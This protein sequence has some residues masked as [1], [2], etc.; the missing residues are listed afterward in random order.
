MGFAQADPIRSP[1]RAQDLIARQR[2]ADY[3]AGDLENLY[4][5]LGLE[6]FFLFAYG[7][8]T[9]SIAE[10]VYP[11]LSPEPLSAFEAKA[12]DFVTEAGATHPSALAAAF[13]RKR[14]INAWGGYSQQTK[15]ALER[16]HHLGHLRVAR[17]EKGIRVYERMPR[18]ATGQDPALR[19]ETILAASLNA[20]GPASRR[21]LLSET[22]HFR[23]LSPTPRSRNAAIERLL[24]AGRAESLLVDGVEYLCPI[25][26]SPGVEPG[27][28]R[29]RILAPFD[30]L[31]R[32]RARFEHLW[33][34]TYRFEAY[35]PPSK[36]KLGYYAM[37]VLWRGAII[38]WANAAAKN[39]RLSLEFGFVSGTKPKDK[40]FT[41]AAREEAERLAA[42]L[43]AKDLQATW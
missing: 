39:G 31:V 35:T 6:E 25:G 32:D 12:L 21:F 15:Q 19:F 4:P 42:F 17:R 14:V 1:A 33:G 38:G 8:G 43:R 40:P 10:A 16:L 23:Y 20:F 18:M 5:Q 3:Q 9:K 26:Q 24:K 34:W 27:E 37:P 28:E 2:V 13:E 29:L 41:K 22:A 30:P 36:R 11:R 7:F